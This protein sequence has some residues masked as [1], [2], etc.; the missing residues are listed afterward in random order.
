MTRHLI[1]L[2]I[3]AALIP[4][5]LVA[6]KGRDLSKLDACKILPGADVEV[7]A[8]G[9]LSMAPVGGEIHCEY[10]LLLP[11]KTPETYDLALVEAKVTEELLKIQKPAEKGT[12][13]PGLWTEAYVGPMMSGKGFTLTAL[14][15]G[16]M[17]IEVQ[18]PRKDI[19]IAL[20]KK[21]VS[22]IP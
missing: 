6:Q 11:D 5:R 21:V 20:A 19:L 4:T 1:A 7:I 2:A 18:G 15:R 22:R 8:K 17:A 12:L 13:V 3:A 16:D 14:R 10:V 9:K